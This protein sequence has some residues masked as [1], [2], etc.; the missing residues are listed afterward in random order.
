MSLFH[1][2]IKNTVDYTAS[3]FG[4]IFLSPIIILT[5]II[6]K[7]D[8]PGPVFFIQ[9]R[10]GKK[11]N[12]FKI[13]KFR[14]MHIEKFSFGDIENGVSA[15]ESRS[16]YIT[17]IKNDPRITR[18]GKFI[19]KYHLDE[20]PQL[21]NVLK[22]EMSLVGPRPDAPAQIA[23][24]MTIHWIRRHV[25]KPGITGLSQI[26]PYQSGKLHSRT[27]IDI[28]YVKNQTIYLDFFILYKTLFKV[29][30][31]SSF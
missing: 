16:Q 7:I 30:R 17:T 24:Y 28:F 21:I 20:L 5:G 14:S 13:Y 29:F 23:D 1:I 6:I 19:R 26:F 27:S 25:V 2:S 3:F 12:I 22:G 18:A 4:L 11:Q 9:K 10:V 8:S 31:G 15:E